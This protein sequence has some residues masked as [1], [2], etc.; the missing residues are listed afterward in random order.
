MSCDTYP[1]DIAIN[2]PLRT[3]EMTWDEAKSSVSHRALRAAC[4]CTQCE[5]A[6][7]KNAA[8]PAAEEVEIE[9]V[10]AVGSVGLQFFFS[11][12][13]NRG[14][15]PWPYLYEIAYGENSMEGKAQ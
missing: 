10:E 12:G 15:Y 6:R 5:S 14:I 8:A 13:H 3:I 7:L 11:D 2:R 9:K 1:S 4:R